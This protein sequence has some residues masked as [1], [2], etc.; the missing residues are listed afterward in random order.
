MQ[1]ASRVAA[2]RM[3]LLYDRPKWLSEGTSATYAQS[4]VRVLL[5][6]LID[7]GR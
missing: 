2:L 1:R 5:R 7:A 4:L 6:V 3:V